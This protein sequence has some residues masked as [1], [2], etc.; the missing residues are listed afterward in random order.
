MSASAS[1][2]VAAKAVGHSGQRGPALWRQAD[3]RILAVHWAAGRIQRAWKVHRWR[4]QFVQFSEVQ[5]RW[6]GS[7]DWLQRHNMLYG[8]ELADHEDVHTWLQERSAAP[9]DREVDPWGSERLLEH[10]NR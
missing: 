5:L 1:A 3:G 4:R 8:T 7:L 6:V 10:L 9:L 2:A